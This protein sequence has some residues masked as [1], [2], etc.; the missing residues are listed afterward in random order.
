MKA[1]DLFS[2]FVAVALVTSS[3]S[4]DDDGK[5]PDTGDKGDT[6]DT[7]EIIVIPDPIHAYAME[8]VE[9][10]TTDEYSSPRVG[11]A[12]TGTGPT[13]HLALAISSSE[14]LPTPDTT[15]FIA[16]AASLVFGANNYL[17][18]SP[19][20]GNELNLTTDF[21]IEVFVKL[22]AL[23]STYVPAG[24]VVTLF[25]RFA[26]KAAGYRL[27]IDADDDKAFFVV[28]V[29]GGDP[30]EVFVRSDAALTAG[31]W[32]HIVAVADVTN[33]TTTLYI[34]GVAQAETGTIPGVTSNDADKIT[35]A[36]D[37][38]GSGRVLDGKLDELNI[39]D[40]A[41]S[42]EQVAARADLL[43]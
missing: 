9:E 4:G 6:G 1:G 11:V 40:V 22:I 3:C 37:S 5:N 18:E 42:A 29:P 34:D 19:D 25:S 28:P 26:S 2:I 39:Y 23:P 24:E 13:N 38:T 15:D 10:I 14:N 36:G 7:G 32:Y 21:S 12:D 35:A 27:A 41:L 17:K 43:P 31:K 20:S 16:G 8:A 30:E 33:G